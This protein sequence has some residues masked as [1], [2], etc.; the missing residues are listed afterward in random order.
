V[1]ADGMLNVKPVNTIELFPI[2]RTYLLETLD[3]LDEKQWFLETA[4]EGWCV[5]DIVQHLLRDDIGILSRKRDRFKFPQSSASESESN[6]GFAEYINT[7]NQEWVEI[8][9]SFSPQLLAELLQFTGRLTY[10]YWQTVDLDEISAEVSWISK[11]T[12]PN[13]TDIAR[14][15]TERWLHQ[16]HIREAVSLPL[17]YE[18]KLLHPFI[19]TYMLAVPLTYESVNSNTGDV[20]EIVVE[21]KAGG[22]WSLQKEQRCWKLHDKMLKKRSVTKITIDQD[23]LWRLF[24]K[25]M[26]KEEAKESARIEGNGVLADYFFNTVCIIAWKWSR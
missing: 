4:C 21:G 10:T 20:I 13:W 1:E 22:N 5:K 11:D 23:K 3:S 25:G 6:R 19:Q 2:E 17:L 12:L 8:S 14:E 16:S 15:Y 18:R 26:S 9:R 24:S 7:K